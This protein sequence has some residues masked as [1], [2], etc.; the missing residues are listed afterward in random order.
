MA[1]F[2]V[3]TLTQI[4]GAVATYAQTVFTAVGTPVRNVILASGLVA[5]PLLAI[6]AM[7]QFRPMAMGSLLAWFVR[8]VVVLSVASSWTQFTPIFN[9]LTNVP[10]SY[11]GALLNA[12]GV[13]GGSPSAPS[14]SLTVSMDNMVTSIFDFSDRA[15]EASSF[16]SISISA[17]IMWVLG[18]FMATVA[19]IVS[20]IA[21]VGLAMSVSLAPIMIATLMFRGT[22][23][24]FESW[25]RFTLGFA[26]IP[27]VLAGIMGAIIAI[28]N[29][30]I[31]TIGSAADLSAAAGFLIV[32]LAAIFMMAQVPTLV[33]GLAGS[34]VAAAGSAFVGGAAR[35]GFNRAAGAVSGTASAARGATSRVLAA[36]REG[37]FAREQDGTGGDI[38]RARLAGLRQNSFVRA[39]RRE[40]LRL[41]KLP[42]AQ[43]S[44]STGR[45]DVAQATAAAAAA[46]SS[47]GG[48]SANSQAAQTRRI[49]S[50]QQ[51]RT[52]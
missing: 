45:S 49:Q 6:N 41:R 13:A 32:V 3:D 12:A 17:I 2:I 51:V 29:M 4:D 16:L 47:T 38:A 52:G 21:K 50:N 19:I 33:S 18:A 20:A 22:S 8:F 43:Q 25:T 30:Q 28:A 7:M 23:Q 15:N 24:L 37:Q 42:G 10:D 5:L 36:R 39:S 35:W 26:L 48:S 31:S 46:S 1:T 27:L 44:S 14:N 11:G 40:E 34:I 9:I